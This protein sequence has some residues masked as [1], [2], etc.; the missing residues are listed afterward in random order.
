MKKIFGLIMV[1]FLVTSMTFADGVKE[2]VKTVKETVTDVADVVKTTAETVNETA[3]V[4]KEAG[5]EFE[6][7]TGISTSTAK[8]TTEVETETVVEDGSEIEVSE[9]INTEVIK[10]VDIILVKYGAAIKETII[11]IFNYS[12]DPA[13]ELFDLFV[14]KV[15][16]YGFVDLG[17]MV[18]YLGLTFLF[19]KWMW[20]GLSLMS[21][22]A[23]Q[24]KKSSIQMLLGTILN[25]G[26]GITF[27]ILS[28]SYMSDTKQIIMDS[29]VPEYQAIK[30]VAVVFGTATGSDKTKDIADSMTK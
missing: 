15:R 10:D 2:T 26:I 12:K 1:M 17:L 16:I 8:T 9:E 21:R 13:K 27:F 23:I 11:D 25:F 4:V 7:T 22:R 14:W 18:L 19:G 24:E 30:D 6:K 29:V 20:K 3:K 5:E 28:L